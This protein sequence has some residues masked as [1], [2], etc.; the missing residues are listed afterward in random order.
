MLCVNYVTSLARLDP[1]PDLLF[2]SGS[3]IT[4]SR[5]ECVARFLGGSWSHL[6]FIDADIGFSPISFRRL[7]C[8][9]YE[10]A[11]AAYPFKSDDVKDQGGFVVD[12]AELGEIGPDG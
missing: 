1:V 3:L 9:G 12:I 6:F 10:I 4:R 11:A 5:N 2:P 7:L 8:S